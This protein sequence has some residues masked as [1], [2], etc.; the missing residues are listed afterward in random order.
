MKI[1]LIKKKKK[2]KAPSGSGYRA[3]FPKKYNVSISTKRVSDFYSSDKAQQYK[4]DYIKNTL[5]DISDNADREGNSKLLKSNIKTLNTLQPELI[6]LCQKLGRKIA[7][8]RV[9]R[10][11]AAKKQKPDIRRSIRKNMDTLRNSS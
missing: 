6:D 10:Y 2:K 7:T 1:F 8:K 5:N 3:A 9:R 4:I 11:K